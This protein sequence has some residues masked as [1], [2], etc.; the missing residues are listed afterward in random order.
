MAINGGVAVWVVWGELIDE[1]SEF[2]LSGAGVGV[3]M[4]RAVLVSWFLGFWFL[5]FLVSKFC[6][7]LVFGFLVSKFQGFTRIPSHAI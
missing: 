4:L 2:G 7:Y 3:G 6:G 1:I 5:G